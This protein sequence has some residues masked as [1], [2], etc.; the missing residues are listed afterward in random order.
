MISAME[1]S[2]D[3]TLI[4][5]SSFNSPA[6]HWERDFRFAG[7]KADMVT[8]PENLYQRVLSGKAN[9]VFLECDPSQPET[10]I[11]LNEIRKIT[12]LPILAFSQPVS[13]SYRVSVLEAGADDYIV[14]PFSVEESLARRFAVLRRSGMGMSELNIQPQA[15]V[16]R[17]MV[18]TRRYASRFTNAATN[19][20]FWIH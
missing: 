8:S 13:V 11:T 10:L 14:L 3:C 6:K 18:V 4:S 16:A 2:A 17:S 7:I 5:L 9:C 1:A 15:T 12:D 20:G 19:G